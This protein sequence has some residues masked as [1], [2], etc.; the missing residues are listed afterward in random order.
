MTVC[1]TNTSSLAKQKEGHNKNIQGFIILIKSQTLR[2][3]R[4]RLSRSFS[5]MVIRLLGSRAQPSDSLA[6]TFSMHAITSF[7]IFPIPYINSTWSLLNIKACS[8]H[9]YRQLQ[10]FFQ[11]IET[12][13][14]GQVNSIEASTGIAIENGHRK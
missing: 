7:L 9:C 3:A 10:L 12:I 6:P 2:R 14:Q 11:I 4:Q 13:V 8:N 1:S 5:V